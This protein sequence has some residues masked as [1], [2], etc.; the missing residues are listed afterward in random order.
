MFE[1]HKQ[2]Q[3]ADLFNSALICSVIANVHRGKGK[4]FQPSDFMPIERKKR[5]KMSIAEM[6]ES[7][8]AITASAGGEIK[9]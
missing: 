6:M 4:S 2:K 9:C 3:S 8:K 7:L 1:R 5:K